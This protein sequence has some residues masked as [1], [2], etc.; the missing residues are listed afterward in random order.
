MQG[1]RRWALDLFAILPSQGGRALPLRQH[2]AHDSLS[3]KTRKGSKSGASGR[4]AGC[5]GSGVKV[6]IRQLGPGMIQQMQQPCSEC[7]GT[8]ETISEEDRC[9]NCK[10]DK[11]VQEKKVL[12]VHV[13]KGMQHGQKI[14]FAGEAD[15]AV[16][17]KQLRDRLSSLSPHRS[18]AN[19]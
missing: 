9:P 18:E 8:G 7:R 16:G 13:E 19:P 2:G 3:L 12:E 4:C 11:V 6:T 17:P 1:V 14:T 5:Q 10:G 15:E